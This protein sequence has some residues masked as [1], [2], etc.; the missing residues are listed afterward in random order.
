MHQHLPPPCLVLQG[1]MGRTSARGLAQAHAL[2]WSGTHNYRSP[3]NSADLFVEML[4]GIAMT[5]AV[6]IE[7]IEQT[8]AKLEQ[9]MNAWEWLLSQ[10]SLPPSS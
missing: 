2:T 8:L 5:Q 6:H 9:L 10:Q 3:G 4:D 1:T 7:R